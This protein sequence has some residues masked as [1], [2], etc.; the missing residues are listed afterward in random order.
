MLFNIN[1][2]INLTKKKRVD[3]KKSFQISNS[4][5]TTKLIKLYS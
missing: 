3:C 1:L 5:P 4:L 2:K